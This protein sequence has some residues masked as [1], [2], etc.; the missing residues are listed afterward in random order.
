MSESSNRPG[1]AFQPELS[2]TS[3]MPFGMH[4]GTPMMDVPVNYLHWFWNNGAKNDKQNVVANY[5][6]KNLSALKMENRDLIWE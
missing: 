4:K 6:R 2:D 5:I 3:P 1:Q